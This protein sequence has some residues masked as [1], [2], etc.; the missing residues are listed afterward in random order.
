MPF[1]SSTVI[2]PQGSGPSV[3][4]LRGSFNIA[5][6]LGYSSNLDDDLSAAY[7]ANPAVV[8]WGHLVVDCLPLSTYNV[9]LQVWAEFTFHSK[10]YKLA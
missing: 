5:K 1:T 10:F 4:C 3:R 9:S 7:N 2:A 6:V 8:A